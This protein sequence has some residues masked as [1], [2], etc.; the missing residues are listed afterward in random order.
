MWLNKGEAMRQTAEKRKEK[1]QENEIDVLVL[2]DDCQMK[3]IEDLF[4]SFFFDLDVVVLML[5][6]KKREKGREMIR[7]SSVSHLH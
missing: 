6:E 3:G 5:D 1:A 2:E 7:S 4:S